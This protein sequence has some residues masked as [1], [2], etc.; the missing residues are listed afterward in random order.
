MEEIFR[1]DVETRNL[2]SAVLA[3]IGDAVL[4]LMFRL[5]FVGDCR[6]SSIHEKVKGYTSKHGQAQILDFLWPL[7]TEEEREVA[8]RAMNSKTAKKHGND[9]LYRKS[10]GFEALVGFLFLKRDYRRI[11]ELLQVVLNFESV[12]PKNSSGSSQK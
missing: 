12:R 7:L 11:E 9:I 1:F 5:K 4:E 8:K 3:Y 2:S 6:V 10:T